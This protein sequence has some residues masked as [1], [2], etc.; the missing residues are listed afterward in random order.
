MVR[1]CRL[2]L[3]DS[4]HQSHILCIMRPAALPT[5]SRP[6]CHGRPAASPHP[7]IARL[8]A[9]PTSP[10]S[11]A[12]GG[13]SPSPASRDRQRCPLPLH[14]C[15]MRDRQRL[16]IPCIP[17]VRRRPHHLH[18]RGT[19]ARP[20][21]ATRAASRGPTHPQHPRQPPVHPRPT[22]PPSCS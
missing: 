5:S 10:T 3:L 13:A 12:T 2:A 1:F 18:I 17:S 22:P 8:A 20:S 4:I 19:A 15:I 9:L 16:P 21:P 7:C 6:L 11:C 14:D